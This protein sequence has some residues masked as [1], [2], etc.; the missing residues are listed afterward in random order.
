MRGLVLTGPEKI[1][2]RSDLPDPTIQDPGDA[3][4]AVRRA[5]I[6]G[7]DLHPYLGREPAAWGLVAG[8]EA[9][10]EIVEVG[11]DV[12]QFSAGDRVFLP[13]TTSC[14]VC[15]NCVAGLSSR[16]ER[17]RLFGWGSPDAGAEVGLNGTQAELV[18]VPLAD[19]TLIAL[20]PEL[21]FEDG[22]LLGDNFTTGFYCAR[23][24][25][26]CEGEGVVVIGCGAVGLSALVS[27]LALGA[28]S[29]VAVDPVR[30]RRE[31]ALRLGADIAVVPSDAPGVM[32]GVRV[33][34][35]AVG[36]RAARRLAWQLVAPGG[37]VS[38][39][40]VATDDFGVS[41]GEL[42]DRNLTWRSG[43]CPV[44]SLMPEILSLIRAG[45]VKIPTHELVSP[46]A[47]SLEDGPQAYRRFASREGSGLKP[48]LAP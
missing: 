36:S 30:L 26:V 9:S 37:T 31:T 5:G 14:G 15:P 28:G 22:V 21:D 29:V 25:G 34:L 42:Y 18:R 10:G 1:E 17:G 11:S 6:C 38:S 32:P 27:A 16:C 41:A 40:G 47:G 48:L 43:R 39:V 44:R 35:E 12:H 46:V 45:T 13:F 7:S 20:P 3:V 4:L 8:H 24:G 19:T 2:Y 23:Q 33:I